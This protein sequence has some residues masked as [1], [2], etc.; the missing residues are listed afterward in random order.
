MN[1]RVARTEE[2]EEEEEEEEGDVGGRWLLPVHLKRPWFGGQCRG[3]VQH[4]H[5]KRTP[6]FSD[7]RI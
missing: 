6:L 4:Q 2:E 3:Q 5:V 7:D 1:A